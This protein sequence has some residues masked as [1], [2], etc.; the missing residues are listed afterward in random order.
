[1][2]ARDAEVQN[3]PVLKREFEELKDETSKDITRTAETL[4]ETFTFHI[5]PRKRSAG[6]DE[7]ELASSQSSKK[8]KME[9]AGVNSSLSMPPPPS[10]SLP[11]RASSVTATEENGQPKI[12]TVAML[13]ALSRSVLKNRPRAQTS[14]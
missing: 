8:D 14:T 10:P 13:R 12:V 1:M 5:R 9:V 2:T 4:R 7:S 6:E 11:S 3:Y